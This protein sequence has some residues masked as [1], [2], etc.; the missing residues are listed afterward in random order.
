MSLV[1]ENL[2]IV[3]SELPWTYLAGGAAAA[4][5]LV[6]L[7]KKLV[8]SPTHKDGVPLPPGPPAMWFW[9]NPMPKQHIAHGLTALVEQYGPVVALRH[10]GNVTIVIGRM[11]AAA[12]I[13]EKEGGALVDRPH[14]IAAADI[15]SRGMRLLLAPAGERFRRLRRAAHSHLQPKAAETYEEIQAE[16]AKDVILDILNDPKR[17]V[18]HA[19]RY[20]ASVILRVT[21]G[22]TSPTSNDDPEMM[23]IR[24]ALTNFQIALRPGAYLVDRIPWLKYVP[25]YGRQLKAFHRYELA[26]FRD[27]L[28]RVRDDM[29]TNTAG[30]SF[31]KTLLEHV[32][33]HRLSDDEMAYLAGSFLGAG[34]DSTTSGITLMIMAAACH[35]DAQA[36][37]QEELDEVVGRDRVP[38]F[39]D[40][41]MLPQLHA[42]ILEALRWRPLAPIGIAHRAMKDIIWGGQCIPAGA[43]VIGCHWA[44]A[45]DPEVF[46]DPEMFN[47]GRWLTEDGRIRT[48]MHFYTYGFGRR[49]CPGQHVADR[50]IYMNLALLL[51]SFRIL[52]RPEAPI[53]LGPDGFRDTIAFHPKPFEV[54]FVPRVEERR[55]REFMA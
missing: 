49:I 53:D 37:V 44:I 30:P 52:Q 33:D 50:S 28:N 6:L 27:Q 17:Y 42:F 2:G 31:G 45:R 24:Q 54:E 10:G 15:L 25:G 26:L 48:N 19:Q 1:N 29:A 55:V 21:Y 7:S 18:Q 36:R 41:D 34:L 9:E 40:R 22:K 35:P 43:T 12:E 3:A 47:P 51:W 13:M 38:T 23:R 8:W 4:T 16:T 32:D 5:A 14:M 11:D 46:P 39:G 20:A